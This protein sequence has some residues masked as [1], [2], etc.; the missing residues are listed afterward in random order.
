V[1]PKK[2]LPGTSGPTTL[3]PRMAKAEMRRSTTFVMVNA[4]FMMLA[5]AVAAWALLPVYESS[6]YVVVTAVAVLGGAGAAVL[7]E[8]LR[9]G[10]SRV[11]LFVLLIYIVAGMTLVVP[12]VLQDPASAPDAALD[13]VRG[14]VFGWKDIVTL[15]LPLGDYGTTLVPVFAL[16]LV[17][18]ATSTWI[19]IRAKRWW[20]L[21]AVTASALV[22]IAIAIGPAVRSD[23]LPWA[24]FGIYASREFLVGIVAFAVIL[25]WFGWRAWYMRRQAIAAAFGAGGV[26]L[27]SSSHASRFAGAMAALAMVAVGI[28]AA[29]LVSAPI[30]QGTPREVVRSAIDPRLAVE[31]Q[32]SP[33][34]SY[35]EYF[36]DDAFG[37]T[38]FTVNV[39]EGDPQR[40]RVATLPYF[41]GEEYSAA[42][43]EGSAVARFQRVPSHVEVDGATEPV[44][45]TVS[46]GAQSGIWVPIVGEL[47]SVDFSGPRQAT[48][49]DGFYYLTGADTGVMVADD[50][51]L[52]GDTYRVDGVVPAEMPSLAAIGTPPGVSTI[53][54]EFIPD[55][56]REWVANQDVS[57]D[58]AGLAELVER[59]RSRGYLSHAVAPPADG[60]SRA[61]EQALPGY[62][63]VTSAAGHSFD[64]VDR[65]FQQLNEREGERG[66]ADNQDLV[67]GVGD[68]EQFAT[69]V[70]M[71]ASD[72][73]FPS[74]VVI[75][76]RLAETDELGWSEPPCEAGVCR[77]ENMSVWTEVQSDKGIW[78]P[79][80]VTPQY[81]DSVAP[82][83]ENQKPPEF[84]S[85]LDPQRA[86]PIVPPL[87]QRGQTD[88]DEPPAE[89]EEPGWL[90]V[91]PALQIAGISLLVIFIVLGPFLAILIWKFARRNRRRRGLARDAVYNGWDEYMDGAVDAGLPPLPLATRTEV[92]REYAT[93]NGAAL[94]T[95]TDGVTFGNVA[96]DD[97]TADQF[98]SLI[99]ADRAELMS[100]KSWWGKLKMRLSLR[101]LWSTMRTNPA[102]QSSLS[103]SKATQRWRSGTGM[104]S[105]HTLVTAS[106]R[107]RTS[108]QS[109][110]THKRKKKS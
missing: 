95:L 12:G 52:S 105:E 71:I 65:L 85:A 36:S 64:R 92:A 53:N 37:A 42:D 59:L 3:G 60:E 93:P 24:P 56:L 106:H 33:L 44:V 81:E 69:A 109:R 31:T 7:C 75:G 88:D 32:V 30:A 13:L 49:V 6:R 101:S 80:D 20:P 55:S 19:A 98:W 62:S 104:R 27:A 15:P 22:V 67:S 110:R 107:R 5:T 28:V 50:G 54:T 87:T 45:A 34:T 96:V 83:I 17:G 39:E 16:F 40:V 47:G 11:A 70:A 97:A 18:T 63:F 9:W 68:D 14:P 46:I 108:A 103:E 102:S 89:E 76:A 2:P 90:W 43:P 66:Q 21:A 78:V 84:A 86:E 29:V 94:A 51:L 41:D 25:S 100:R 4:L 57:A 1:S 73:G 82:D 99:A 35:R 8:R 72:M 91:I 77:G 61:W 10:A 48:L 26:R 38:L 79:V 23:P 58:A 74:R